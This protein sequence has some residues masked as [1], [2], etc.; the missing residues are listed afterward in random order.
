MPA[1][2][3]ERCLPAAGYHK[4]RAHTTLQPDHRRLAM[5]RRLCPGT[6][7][8]LAQR[9]VGGL[10]IHLV[11]KILVSAVTQDAV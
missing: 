7:Q 9:P 10:G 2:H 6:E 4:L 11:R 8:P 3:P 5:D 1:A